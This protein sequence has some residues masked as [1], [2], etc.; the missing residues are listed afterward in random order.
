MEDQRAC[1]GSC[2]GQKQW[3]GSSRPLYSECGAKARRVMA[4][5]L[6]VGVATP[7][8]SRLRQEQAAL[9]SGHSDALGGRDGNG[10]GR[11]GA[12]HSVPPFDAPETQLGDPAT[13]WPRGPR[14]T[15]FG[16][17]AGLTEMA[18]DRSGQRDRHSE[19]LDQ[20]RATRITRR[21]GVM[22][23]KQLWTRLRQRAGLGDL[24]LDHSGGAS[25]R[26]AKDWC[27]KPGDSGEATVL[28]SPGSR[29]AGLGARYY[30]SPQPAG[31]GKG[32]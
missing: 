2:A 12:F 31:R 8:V 26:H 16:E 14:G 9:G 11:E 4:S 19:I 7:H 15:G 6:G 30:A 25:G 5:A 32:F 1:A 10:K 21:R 17:P 13:C 28:L 3:S 18:M 20:P 27:V 29:F 24:R 22:A 23:Q